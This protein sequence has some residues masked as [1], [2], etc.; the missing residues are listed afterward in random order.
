[1]RT[2]PSNHRLST[3]PPPE[4]D[5]AALPGKLLILFLCIVPFFILNI[6]VNPSAMERALYWMG[7]NAACSDYETYPREWILIGIASLTAVWFVL[8]RFVLRRPSRIASCAAVRIQWICAGIYALTALL[9]GLF[10][11]YRKETWLGTVGLYEGTLAL[12]SYMILFLGMTYFSDRPAVTHFFQN[13][14]HG[15]SGIAGTYWTRLL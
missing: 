10:S 11:A 12:I 5:Y 4:V 9:S 6:A 1:M 7:A 3:T 13:A 15:H 2:Q 8:E 14:I